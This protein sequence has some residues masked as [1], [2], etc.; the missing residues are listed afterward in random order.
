MFFLCKGR[1]FAIIRTRVTRFDV[2]VECKSKCVR[3]RADAFST[4]ENLRK[5]KSTVQAG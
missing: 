2:F 4:Y 3:T 1:I 5:R